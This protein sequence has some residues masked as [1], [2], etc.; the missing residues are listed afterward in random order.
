MLLMLILIKLRYCLIRGSDG[1]SLARFATKSY[2]MQMRDRYGVVLVFFAIIKAQI[3]GRFPT[4]FDLVDKTG[5]NMHQ[6]SCSEDMLTD[7]ELIKRYSLEYPNNT[8]G[9]GF[10]LTRKGRRLAKNFEMFLME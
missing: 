8:L 10:G 1:V 6:I 9:S 7:A 2:L 5:L 3:K 4:T